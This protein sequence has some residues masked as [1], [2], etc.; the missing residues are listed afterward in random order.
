[1]CGICFIYNNADKPVDSVTVE[2]MVSSM[3]HRGPDAQHSFVAGR[4]GLGHSR[5]LPVAGV[6][7]RRPSSA[8]DDARLTALRIAP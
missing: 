3:A 7:L 4:A 1:M 8:G 5:L 2:S 6:D